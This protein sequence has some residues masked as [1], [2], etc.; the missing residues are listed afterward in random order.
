MTGQKIS[1]Y[2]VLDKLGEGG[3]GVVYRA[4]DAKLGRDVALKVLSAAFAGN[5][6][7]MARFQREA[8]VLASLNHPNIAAIHGLEE[9]DG[10]RAL[11]MELVEGPTLAGRIAAGPMPLHE[12]LAV[13]RQI[14]EALEYAHEKGVVHRDLKPAN[15]KITPEGT[16][17]VLDFGLAKAA[18]GPAAAADQSNSPTL[19]L[20]AT[21]A[22]VILGT[23]AYMSPE[24]ASGKPVDKRADIWSFGVVVWEMLSG[25]RLFEGETVSH[26]LADVLRAEIDANKLPEGTPPAIRDLVRR[27]LDRDVK[28]RLRDIGEARIALQRYLADPGG[29]SPRIESP[30]VAPS[31]P[32][33]QPPALLGGVGALLVSLA[34]VAIIHFRERPPDVRPVRFSVAQPD[35][36]T[37]RWFDLPVISPD[38]RRLAFT[39]A[40]GGGN[41]ML[42]IRPL[43][44][45]EAHPMTGTENAYF[46]FWSPDS[47]SVAFF[48][49]GKLKRVDVAGGPPL[50]LC[51]TAAIGGGGTWNRNGVIVFASG[52]EAL[53]HVPASGGESKI[54]LPL[55]KARQETAQLWPHFLPDGRH[56]LYQSRS[57]K[58][59]NGI[60]RASLDSSESQ[61]VVSSD[62]TPGFS[63]PGFLLFTRQETL[64]AQPFDPGKLQTTGEAFPIAEGVGRTADMAGS[65]YS[66]SEEGTM[67]FRSGNSANLRIASYARDGKGLGTAGEP[68]WYRQLAL[69]PDGKRLVVERRDPRT[70]T[71]D[72]WLLE[73]GSNILSRLTFDPGNDT[74]PVWSP[75]GR[76]VAFSSDRGGAMDLYRKTVGSGQEELLFA[77]PERKVAECWLKDGSIVF[78]NFQ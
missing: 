76:Q 64:L 5:A 38:G 19:T 7:R 60:Y 22:G 28:S 8:Q 12:S 43:D 57:A 53:R 50:A 69:S 48:G 71:W 10:V 27:C 58:G 29:V 66:V 30:A 77:S 63:P 67:V 75:D 2:E 74:D 52:S 42:W 15:V 39:G 14:A 24:Q 72:I 9:S 31:P 33:R 35:K 78:G 45:L 54:L 62:A 18:E 47:R 49:S 3:M 73:L 55:N 16:V 26:T 56:F 65:L 59:L 21:Q 41:S 51:D 37:Y 46:P 32:R 11:A 1:H 68:A 44:S 6:D 17:K 4:R 70:T 34:T 36:V 13:A 23:A 25:R 61:L 20:A 40:V